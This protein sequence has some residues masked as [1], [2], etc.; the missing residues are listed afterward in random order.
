[1]YGLTLTIRPTGGLTFRRM[2]SAILHISTYPFLPPTTM[3]GWLRRLMMMAHSGEYP[4][5]AVK[6][7]SYFAMPPDYY[8]LGAYSEPFHKGRIHTTKRHGPMFQSKHAVFSRLYRNKK[9][10]GNYEKLQLHTWEYLIVDQLHGYV[11]HES[12]T[13]LEALR[14]L[15]NYGCKIGKEGFAYLEAASDVKALRQET[16]IARPST[17]LPG[18]QMIGKQGTLYPLYRYQYRQKLQL[19]PNLGEAAPSAIEGFVPFW[20]GWANEPIELNYW[21]DGDRY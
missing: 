15:V 19:D 17:L 7:P 2:P 20:A 6:N 12:K 18:E 3:S 1:M 13:A 8:I 10:E 14:Q 21:T 16:A 11:L 5:T 4:N 9:D